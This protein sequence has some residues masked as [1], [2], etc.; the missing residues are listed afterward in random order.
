[1]SATGSGDPLE[2]PEPARPVIVVA[3]DDPSVRL[4]F[5]RVL[6]REGFRILEAA[7]GREAIAVARAAS[8]S[9]MLLDLHMPEMDG[10]ETLRRLRAD[11]GLQTLPVILVTGST[12]EATRIG[13]LDSGA[14]DV[15]VKPVSINELV[16][17]VRTQIRGRTAWTREV[18][19][20][21]LNRRKLSAA[22]AE[23]PRDAPLGL[24]AAELAA[25]LP[26]ILDLGSVAVLVFERGSAR[27]LAASG[28]LAERFEPL[29]MVPPAVGASF[30]KLADGGPWLADLTPAGEAADDAL[31][32]AIVPFSIGPKPN[33]TGCL[34]Y[35]RH[36]AVG[37]APL[38]HRLADLVDASEAIVTI[39]RPAMEQAAVLAAAIHGLRRIIAGRRFAIHLQ[40]I[41][42]LADGRTMGA[43]ALTRF[44]DGV[45]PDLRF[46]EAGV[47]GMGL[48]LERATLTAAVAAAADLPSD[49][50]LSLN[51]SPEALEHDRELRKIV[52]RA[53]RPVI[54]ELTEHDRIDDY[55]AIR[56][57]FQRLDG[58]VQL[59][60]DDAGSGYA[61]LRHILSLQPAYVK[62]DMSW[63][64]DI[65]ADPVR[66]A[67]VAGLAY[68]ARETH[69][70]LIAEGI[71]SER[72]LAA[73][74]ELG[75]DLGQGYLLGR[76]L[77][78]SAWPPQAPW[79]EARTAGSTSWFSTSRQDRAA[80]ARRLPD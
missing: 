73:L 57:A 36:P 58:D 29:K 18:E 3:D 32:A 55:A 9:L 40:P 27:S 76:P 30:L 53:N 72:E 41:A 46:A 14:D 26:P 77:P 42:R 5:R 1:V 49:I 67:L 80:G 11:G 22:L 17:R 37:H 70:Q 50:A 7:N 38:A 69:C 65:D 10:L 56:A 79:P 8:A 20:G 6:E 74:R 16:A 19:S 35:G 61:S 2:L 75:I 15:V 71:E 59:A 28:R 48:A 78:S 23:L 44:D 13:G 66:R 12:G 25:T 68:F 4:L 31:D 47:L 24:L 62:L 21:R 39:L 45:R 51:V 54:V 34:V 64:R 63:V 52:G 60:V 43:E 33:P